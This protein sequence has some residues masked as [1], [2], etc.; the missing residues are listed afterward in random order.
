MVLVDAGADDP[1]RL[2]GNGQVV[3]ASELVRG[4]PIPPVRT[5]GPLSVSEIPPGALRAMRAGLEPAAATANDPP[6]DKLPSDAQ[7]MRTW[8]LGQLGHVAATVNPVEIEELAWLRAE[9]AKQPTPLGDRPLVVLTRGMP[10][11]TGPDAP[12]QEAE[13]RRDHE[14]I[15]GLSRQGRLVVATKSRHHVQLDEPALVVQAIREVVTATR[16]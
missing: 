7:R 1:L 4:R 3:R 16:P 13:H 9:R 6:R 11:E 2:T 12:A 15:A 5:T 10:E 14:K 8:A